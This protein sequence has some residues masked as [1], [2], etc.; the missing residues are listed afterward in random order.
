M[1]NRTNVQPSVLISGAS[2][3]GLSLAYWLQRY[4]YDVTV[5]E[6]GSTPRMGGAPIDVR[7]QAI[8][9]VER[10]G[11]LP[12]IRDKEITTERMEF[13]RADNKPIGSLNTSKDM[14][15]PRH[16]IELRR[17]HLVTAL[18]DTT[19]AGGIRYI[20]NDSIKTLSQDA[21]GVDISFEHAPARRFDLVFGADGMHS[22]VRR[23]TFGQ[24]SKFVKFLGMYV[25]LV[26]LPADQDRRKHWVS[27]YNVSGKMVAVSR[28]DDQTYAMFVFR[29]QQITYDYHNMDQKKQLVSQAFSNE[30]RWEIPDL[31]KSV[32]A[33]DNL[34]FDSVSQI[35]MKTW[36]KGRVALLGDSAHCAAFLS[37][38]GSSLAIIGAA[39]LADSLAASNDEHTR[40]FMAYEQKLRP[41]VE[42]TQGGVSRAGHF[43]VPKTRTGLWCRN[44]ALRVLRFAP[45]VGPRQSPSVK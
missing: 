33:S 13:V 17:D 12:L 10:M 36:S 32:Q 28:Y 40:A 6:V 9:I 34:Y 2:I 35:R 24:E 4:G 45:S 22:I 14:T 8:D 3:A 15:N 18:Y 29:G 11:I 23:L 25:G 42:K 30:Q 38:M 37:G 26:E 31:L 20:F 44:A 16:D 7:G 41:L 21:N 43:L 5:V 1:M 27:A 39:A 19:I